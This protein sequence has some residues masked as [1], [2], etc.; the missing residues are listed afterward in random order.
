MN[1]LV[2]LDRNYLPP[3]RVML[4]SLLRNDPGETFEIYAIGDGLLPEDW[5]ALEELCGGRGRSHPLEVPADLFADA[6]VARY[7]TRAM[8]YRL[9]AAE[10]LPR[11]LDRVLYL[12]PDILVINPVGALYDTDLEGDLM[13]AA[14]HTGLLAGITDPVNR[15]RLENYEAEAYYN[16]GV[17]LMDARSIAATAR[18]HGV[19]TS[20]AEVDYPA[21]APVRRTFD[22]GV[23]G[24]RVYFG[25]GKARP[26][27]PLHY[28]PNIAE[29]PAI[30]PLGE[31]LL[32]QVASVLRDPVTTTDELIPSG[33]TSS[34]R[35]DPLKLA[36]FALSRRDPDYVPRARATQALEEARRS[37]AMPPELQ[38]VQK[39]LSIPD[40]GRVQ[41]GS[42]LF[43]NK[44][45]DGSAREQAA[46]CQR[47][48]G[49]CANLCYEFATKRY[50][51]NCVNWGMLP[52]TLAE[53]TDF[54]G[55]P[56]DF[57]YVPQVREKVARGDEEF[58]ALLL[59]DSGIHALTLYLKN[60]TAEEREL[61]LTGCLINH[62]AAQN[63]AENRR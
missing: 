34:Y 26:E 8:Y 10:L 61:L 46:S 9:L 11:S 12:D 21:P 29:W 27:A 42:V 13:A 39:V 36:S 24:R 40:M 57:L 38:S 28:G 30:P 33:E 51:S 63:A 6:P 1:I 7:W 32:L 16:S 18:N 3:L 4:G 48:L 20:A 55:R 15:L 56:G 35:S 53:G 43:A 41:I 49:G 19:V 22:G 60:T 14:T 58:P 54:P 50:R 2:T 25:Y 52:F 37:G 31:E 62:Y 47:V 45:G 23:Y 5:A 17:L 59:T 44:P